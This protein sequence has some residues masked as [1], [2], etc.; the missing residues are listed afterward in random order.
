MGV[1]AC[2][3]SKCVC[4]NKRDHYLM[5]V[6]LHTD[7]HAHILYFFQTLVTTREEESL[8][9][10]CEEDTV[11]CQS[12]AFL[13]HAPSHSSLSALQA[14]TEVYSL[15]GTYSRRDNFTRT[16]TCACMRTHTLMVEYKELFSESHLFW[17]D[18]KNLHQWSHD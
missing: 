5:A 8:L 6:T 11:H 10:E 9:K 14:S 3:S 15:S 12:A 17:D 18:V 1:F 7:P 4:L 16:H 2:S 13:L